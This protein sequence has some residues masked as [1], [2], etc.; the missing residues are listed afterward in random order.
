MSYDKPRSEDIDATMAD[1]E[2]RDID[3]RYATPEA[4]ITALVALVS[5]LE[6]GLLLVAAR[7]YAAVPQVEPYPGACGDV[8]RQ[9]LTAVKI[10]R[11]GGLVA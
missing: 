6:A 4:K 11:K 7:H 3:T 5:A 8:V 2:K 9:C 10:A 1:V